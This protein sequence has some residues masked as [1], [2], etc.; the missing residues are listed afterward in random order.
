MVFDH[1]LGVDPATSVRPGSRGSDSTS[2]VNSLSS[3][4]RWA[5]DTSARIDFA[6]RLDWHDRRRLL[7]A[8]FPVLS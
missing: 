7:K 8:R 5:V 3:P 6:T 4:S 2:V 1:V